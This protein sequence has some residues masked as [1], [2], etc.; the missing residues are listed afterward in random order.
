VWSVRS[1]D[2]RPGQDYFLDGGRDRVVTV[3]DTPPEVRSR[4]RVRVRFV[5][6]IKAGEIA[7][8]PSRRILAP[9]GGLAP[10]APRSRRPRVIRIER[11]PA[12]GDE[13]HWEQ[14]GEIIWKVESVDADTASVTGEL[15]GKPVTKTVP[16]SELEVRP[17]VIEP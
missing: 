12:A 6:G 13:V 9:V 3:L 16:L 8:V 4:A 15:F 17:L 2:M 10:S 1:D 14:T 5:N 7:E 11:A